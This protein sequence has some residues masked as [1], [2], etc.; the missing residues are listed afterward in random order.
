[1]WTIERLS[2]HPS[3]LTCKVLHEFVLV[4]QLSSFSQDGH[5]GSGREW[6]LGHVIICLVV[7]KIEKCFSSLHVNYCH[8]ML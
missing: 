6:S 5:K 2:Q 7:L 8:T 1:M 4:D 3:L